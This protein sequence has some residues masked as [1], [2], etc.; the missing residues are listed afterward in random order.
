VAE[1]KKESVVVQEAQQKQAD[2]VE[3][4]RF[5][6]VQLHMI[7]SNW[8]IMS[9]SHNFWGYYVEVCNNHVLDFS[10]RISL[11]ILFS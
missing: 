2:E 1:L 10:M 7:K 8:P 6:Q 11:Y 4:A 3:S 9:R 5:G